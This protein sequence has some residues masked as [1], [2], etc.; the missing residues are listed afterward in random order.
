MNGKY[1]MNSTTDELW[2]WCWLGLNKDNNKAKFVL[3][4]N[5]FLKSKKTPKLGGFQ[6][7]LFPD[8]MLWETVFSTPLLLMIRLLNEL[9]Y[10]SGPFVME[11]RIVICFG[12][13]S[14]DRLFAIWLIRLWLIWYLDWFE[15]ER[16]GFVVE[17]F[18]GALRRPSE[19]CF[20]LNSFKSFAVWFRNYWWDEWSIFLLAP[21]PHPWVRNQG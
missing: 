18:D 5:S 7:T 12:S 16:V 14:L 15:F 20:P 1:D 21:H 11:L 13:I 10:L 19:D 8:G 3:I 6:K 2:L 17:V 9:I 4:L